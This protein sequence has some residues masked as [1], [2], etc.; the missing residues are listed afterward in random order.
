MAAIVAF[1]L[2]NTRQ[3]QS[4]DIRHRVQSSNGQWLCLTIAPSGARFPFRYVTVLVNPLSRL[5]RTHYHF[6]G[7]NAVRVKQPL[8]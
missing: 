6:I 7:R 1:S 3:A 4:G 2:V 5:F 8:A